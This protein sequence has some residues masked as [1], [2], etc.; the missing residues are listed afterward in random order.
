MADMDSESE[1]LS[2]PITPVDIKK[3]IRF[4]ITFYISNKSSLVKGFR[5]TPPINPWQIFI[6][7]LGKAVA[8]SSELKVVA[9]LATSHIHA[10]NNRKA[11]TYI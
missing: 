6:R 5:S 7:K 1:L 9:A 3:I 10:E 8:L 11:K 2:A 4:S